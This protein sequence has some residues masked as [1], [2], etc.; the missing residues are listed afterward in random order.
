MAQAEAKDLFEFWWKEE[1]LRSVIFKEE[2]IEE[3]QAFLS[4]FKANLRLDLHN[5]ADKLDPSY[6]FRV[7]ACI[8]SYVGRR[9]F[10]RNLARDQVKLR[11]KTGQIQFGI[12]VFERG[13]GEHKMRFTSPGSKAW[14]NFMLSVEPYSAV[15]LEI[16]MPKL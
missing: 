8:L 4:R 12:L 16:L 15:F 7:P 5:V 1:A 10:T 11:L 13:R 14:V 6:L 3:A 2:Q 9:S